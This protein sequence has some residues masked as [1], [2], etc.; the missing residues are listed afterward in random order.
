MTANFSNKYQVCFLG[1]SKHFQ[2]K[3]IICTYILNTFKTITKY[4]KMKRHTTTT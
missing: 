4:T 2:G 1:I 3:L